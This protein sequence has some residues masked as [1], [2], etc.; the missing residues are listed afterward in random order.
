MHPNVYRTFLVITGL[1]LS[2]AGCLA[3]DAKLRIQ[4]KPQ[5]AYIFVDGSPI[6][7][8]SRSISVAPGKHTIGVYNYGY[9]PEVREISVDEDRNAGLNFELVAVP[10]TISGPWGR[11][12]IEGAARAAVYLN[13]KTPEYFVGH[14]DEFNNSGYWFDCCTQQLIVPV[15][16]HVVTVVDAHSKEL[17]S[18]SVS[19]PA[20]KRVVLYVPSGKQKVKNWPEGSAINSLPRFTAGIASASIAVAP[21][22]GSVSAEPAKINCG[23]SARVSWQTSETVERTIT[24]DSETAKQPDAAG[25]LSVQPKKATTYELKAS[26]PGGSVTSSAAVDV[27]TVVQSSINVSPAQIQYRRIGDKVVQQGSSNLDWTAANASSVTIDPLGSVTANGTK[28]VPITPK[29]DTNGPISEVQTFTLTAKNDCGGS[30]THTASVQLTGSIE[31]IPEISLVSVFF[32]TGFPDARHPEVGLVQS[33]QQALDRMAAGFKKYL[34]YDPDARLTV[35]GNTDE[36]DSNARNKPLSERRANRV[37]EYLVST[38]IPE[39]KI[40][41]VANG[42]TQQLDAGTVTS[43]HSA[44]PNKF[45]ERGTFQDLVWAYNRRVDIVLLPKDVRS[46][47]YFPGDAPEAKFLADSNWPGE[48]ELVV[49]A[50]EKSRLPD[51][52]APAH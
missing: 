20:D 2:T 30:D 31:P 22:S 42:K 44:N 26:G 10:G 14:V 18:G 16:T 6:G 5:Q 51:D 19:V 9:K 47:Q 25:N 39:N 13:G 15:G 11:I 41:T 8:G 37:K 33:Q 3:K 36:R 4:V 45:A 52:P 40:E 28:A 34:E 23:D 29:Q 46:T 50:A 43:L 12:Q 35:V 49:L 24:A 1:A 17:W 27:N 32:P 7:D 21:V 48:K 38:G